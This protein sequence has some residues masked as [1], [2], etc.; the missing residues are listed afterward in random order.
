V[1][2]KVNSSGIVSDSGEGEE[3]EAAITN[4]KITSQ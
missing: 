1:T 4:A 2:D 3:K